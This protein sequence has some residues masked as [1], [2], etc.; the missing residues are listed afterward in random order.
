M[1]HCFECQSLSVSVSLSLPVKLFEVIETEKTL[2]LIMD[3][4][5]GGECNGRVRFI[6]N[7][8]ISAHHDTHLYMS[9]FMLGE[10]FDYLVA[11][12]RMK[13]KEARAKF[14]QVRDTHTI[15]TSEQNHCSAEF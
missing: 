13:E 9:L 11:H 7:I 10:V 6:V 12:G 2:Y 4:A 15:H 5:S 1:L 14:R 3:Y 8:T